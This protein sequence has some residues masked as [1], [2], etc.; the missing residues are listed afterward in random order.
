MG[1]IVGVGEW[2]VLAC[3]LF[4]E[5]CIGLRSVICRFCTRAPV[6]QGDSSASQHTVTV[7]VLGGAVPAAQASAY[8]GSHGN[9][10]FRNAYDKAPMHA[11]EWRESSYSGVATAGRCTAHGGGVCVSFFAPQP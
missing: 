1:S 4:V 7:A 5:R 10:F 8:G 2:Y 3:G 6:G 11:S 9:S